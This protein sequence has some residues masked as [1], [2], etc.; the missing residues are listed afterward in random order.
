MKQGIHPKNLDSKDLK[1]WYKCSP[2]SL[3]L[4]LSR[5]VSQ[6][7]WGGSTLTVTGHFAGRHLPRGGNVQEGVPQFIASLGVIKMC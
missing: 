3:R 5:S 2:I 6:M 1:R 7:T 4:A